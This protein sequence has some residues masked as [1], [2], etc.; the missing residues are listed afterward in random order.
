MKDNKNQQE[1]SKYLIGQGL[2]II[3]VVSFLLWLFTMHK[4]GFNTS[5]LI[6]IL[7][8]CTYFFGW[9]LIVSAKKASQNSEKRVLLLE[10]QHTVKELTPPF[11]TEEH[12]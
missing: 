5:L 2:L 10:G 4:F 9:G 6:L 12:K 11:D 3:G 1:Q 8:N 7:C